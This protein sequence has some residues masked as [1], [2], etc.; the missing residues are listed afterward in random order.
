VPDGLCGVTLGDGDVSN[1]EIVFNGVPSGKR[2]VIETVTARCYVPPGQVPFIE[3]TTVLGTSPIDHFL[4]PVKTGV[5][6][7]SEIFAATNAVRLYADAGTIVTFR[8]SRSLST[9]L[10]GCSLTISGYLEDVP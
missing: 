5:F 9:G 8:F 6:G 2:L 3:L 4:A 7:S 10:A 1:T